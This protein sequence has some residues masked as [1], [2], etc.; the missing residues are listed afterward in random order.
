MLRHHPPKLLIWLIKRLLDGA[1]C[2]YALGDFEER[3][4]EYVQEKGFWAAQIFL[5]KQI[6]YLLPAFFKK[7]IIWS[8][9]MLKNT[10]TVTLRLLK[11]HR[12]YAVINLGGLAVGLAACLFIGLYIH[13]ELSYD[14]F[15]TKY[16]RIFRLGHAT[17]GWPYGRIIATDF[18]E[19]EAVTYIRT[20]PTYSIAHNGQHLFENMF[21]ADADFFKIFNFPMLQGN[22]ETVLDEPYSLVLSDRL[23]MKLFGSSPALDHMVTL[24]KSHLFKVTGVVRNPR[25]S[26]IQFD[27]ILSFETLR[28][29]DKEWFETE[30]SSGWLDL[31]VINYI[32]LREGA[33]AEEFK[34]KIR[35]LPRQHAGAYLDRW[36]TD[37]K[38]DVEPLGRIYLQ[39]RYGNWLGPHS[40]IDYVWLL[41]FV[42]LFLLII[43]GANFINLAT[44]RSIQRAKEVGIRKV[45]GSTRR[46]LVRQFMIESFMTCLL[47]A[48]LA[49]GIAVLMLPHF[50][51]LSSKQF[52]AGD[53]FTP[54]IMLGMLGL[55]FVVSVLAGLY[56]AFSLSGFKPIEVL[57]GRYSSG[58]KGIRLRQGL[59]VIQFAIS[60]ALIIGTLVILSQLRYMGN[61][62][63]GFDAE[64]VMVLDAQRAPWEG[65]SQRIEAFKQ[66]LVSH[67]AVRKVSSMGTVPGRAGWRGQIS[68]PEGWPDDKSLSLEYIPVDYDFVETL[69]LR[70]I[71]GRDF[72]S[73]YA[74]D[75]KT[76]LLINEAAVESA[77]WPSPQESIGKR[78]ASPGSRKPDGVVVGVLEDYHH[79]GLRDKIEP[80]MFGIRETNGFFALRIDADKAAAVD[81]HVRRTWKEFFQG[82]PYTLSFQDEYFGRQY[83]QDRRLMQIFLTFT[84]LTILIACMGL[85]GLTAYTASQRTKEIGVRKV[86]GASVADIVGLLSRRFLK[87]VFIAFVIAAPIGYFAME[88]WLQN[89]AYRPAIR[90]EVF[91]I[92]AFLLFLIAI[93]TVSYQAVKAALTDPVKSLRH[94]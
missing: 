7:S 67:T 43:A 5:G 36:G 17:V 70:I 9:I 66:A 81:R 24:G 20:Y 90:I 69:G 45:V 25:H 84:G 61:Q 68:F 89:F 75:K 77:L 94:E 10:I 71:A 14:R 74:T 4:H 13:E 83:E 76:A 30:M 27:A 37:Y 56:P 2:D 87:L 32:L 88:R 8:L 91:L 47:S 15:H 78:F 26:H 39:S 63:L 60:S 46:T 86:L 42:G 33:D 51:T 64:Q 80:M 54:Y 92:N 59:V 79:H 6:L 3:F 93:I 48:V 85:F 35:D 50:N 82:Y 41:A 16:D 23:A 40:D 53:I 62:D 11:R 73:S 38:L 44:S 72:D 22:P 31:N 21:F 29:L 52:E 19:V 58:H 12:S 65:L 28:V 18:P 55:V 34:N 57:R 49:V 1:V